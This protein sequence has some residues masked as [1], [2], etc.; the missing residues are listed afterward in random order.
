MSLR[1]SQITELICQG[2]PDRDISRKLD[3][4]VNTLRHHLK[5]VYR[6]LGVHSRVQLVLTLNHPHPL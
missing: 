2:L 1:E 3:I 4:K 5:S 6:K